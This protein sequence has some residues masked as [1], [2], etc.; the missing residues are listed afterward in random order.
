MRTNRPTEL[1]LEG[2]PDGDSFQRNA[3]G[4]HLLLVRCLPDWPD[5]GHRWSS[6]ARFPRISA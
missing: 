2:T 1:Q 3:F 6:D 4:H 5:D